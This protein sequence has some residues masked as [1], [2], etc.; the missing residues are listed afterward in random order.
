MTYVTNT[1]EFI[2]DFYDSAKH[3][4]VLKAKNKKLSFGITQLEYVVEKI[5]EITSQKTSNGVNKYDVPEKIFL[6][7]LPVLLSDDNDEF[8]EWNEV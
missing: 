4:E 8:N 7:P 3:N 6:E 5:I 2:S 1:G